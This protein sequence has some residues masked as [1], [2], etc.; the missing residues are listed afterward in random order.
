MINSVIIDKFYLNFVLGARDG[1]WG[2]VS[3]VVFL[4]TMLGVSVGC[5]HTSNDYTYE[6]HRDLG[7]NSYTPRL[8]KDVRELINLGHRPF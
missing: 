6:T 4:G 5:K 1:L 2:K 3:M 8:Q 7:K